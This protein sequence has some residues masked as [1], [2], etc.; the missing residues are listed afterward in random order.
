MLVKLKRQSND[1][2]VLYYRSKR[3]ELKIETQH[4]Q[5]KNNHQTFRFT[6]YVHCYVRVNGT[7]GLSL[8]HRLPS[9]VKV[10]SDS[11]YRLIIVV[12]LYM[13]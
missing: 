9:T 8:H 2:I 3:T 13:L 5:H 7:N 12:P 4:F 6:T 11:L 10:L 1:Y